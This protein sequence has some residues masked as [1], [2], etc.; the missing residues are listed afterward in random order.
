MEFSKFWSQLKRISDPDY[1]FEKWKSLGTQALE[2][3]DEYNPKEFLENLH[4][5]EHFSNEP[6]LVVALFDIKSLNVIWHTDNID[7]IFGYSKEDFKKSGMLLFFKSLRLSHKL[8][9]FQAFFLGL[10]IF[11]IAR[12][13]QR[14]EYVGAQFFGLRA[15]NPKTK[16]ENAFFIR[17]HAIK[18]DKNNYPLLYLYIIENCT[19]LLKGERYWGR[20][21]VGKTDKLIHHFYSNDFTTIKG[22][23]LTSRE[24]EILKLLNNGMESINIGKS[25]FISTHTVD[26]HRKNMIHKT[27]AVNTTAL[28]QIAKMC[29]II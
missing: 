17:Q 19:H 16:E 26:K 4:L 5:I 13:N 2:H 1:L 29:Q 14:Q 8:Y 9:L 7:E 12:E 10:K 20:V 22:D 21:Q 18:Q 6:N 27:G 25:L 15:E 3:V 28:L 11:K 23:I 24:I